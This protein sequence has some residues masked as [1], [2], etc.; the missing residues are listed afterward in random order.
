MEE[1]A[2]MGIGV[3]VAAAGILGGVLGDMFGR[4]LWIDR[5]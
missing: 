3:V 1:A 2:G 4:C 5:I